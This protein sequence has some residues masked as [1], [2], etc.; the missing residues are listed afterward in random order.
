[1]KS[2]KRK[3]SS[4]PSPI[5]VTGVTQFMLHNVHSLARLIGCGVVQGQREDT[6]VGFPMVIMGI[7]ITPAMKSSMQSAGGCNSDLARFNTHGLPHTVGL[8]V[9]GGSL[10]HAHGS[11]LGFHRSLKLFQPRTILKLKGQQA[12]TGQLAQRQV[13]ERSENA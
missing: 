12:I 5:L 1:M 7:R 13:V 4:V 6:G 9:T 11:M 3:Y 2:Q 8:C 10:S